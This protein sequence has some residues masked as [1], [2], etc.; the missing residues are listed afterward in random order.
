MCTVT[1]VPA[2]DKAFVT[3]NRDE[4][5]SR[6]AQLRPSVDIIK[7]KKVTYPKD[8]G[9]GGSWFAMNDSGLVAVLLNGAF[10]NHDRRPPYAKS[11]GLVVLDIVSNE[12]PLVYLEEMDLTNIEPFTL[13]LFD[14]IKLVEFRWDGQQKHIKPLDTSK[15]YIWSSFTLYDQEAQEV[16]NSYFQDFKT[17]GVDFNADSILRFHKEN[18]GDFENGFVVDRKNGLKTLSITQ[19]ECN[20][21]GLSMGHL[22]L[23]SNQTESIYLPLA[24]KVIAQS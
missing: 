12:Q 2:R 7:G 1:Y 5:I 17:S 11:R 6:R 8:T 18:H 4:H 10:S 3:S 9:A 21:D 22:D 15:A 24:P 14:Q 16:R 20:E 19:V 13:V 23:D